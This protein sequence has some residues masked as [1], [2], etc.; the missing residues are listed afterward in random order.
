VQAGGSHGHENT[1]LCQQSSVA[2]CCTSP[3]HA[4][5]AEGQARLIDFIKSA[6]A[7]REAAPAGV[8]A[9]FGKPYAC[10]GELQQVSRQHVNLCSVTRTQRRQPQLLVRPFMVTNGIYN[11]SCSVLQIT[12]NFLVLG[13]SASNR[14]FCLVVCCSCSLTAVQHH[15]CRTS[16]G[17]T[18]TAASSSAGLASAAAARAHKQTAAQQLQL[19]HWQQAVLL[20]QQLLVKVCMW[21]AAGHIA[22]MS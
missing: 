16:T 18:C 4:L 5:H 8:W 14:Y 17:M 13:S 9:S 6:A 11:S 21:F 15:C 22:C 1:W 2:F 19:Q 10:L 20:K 7:E 12:C 3:A